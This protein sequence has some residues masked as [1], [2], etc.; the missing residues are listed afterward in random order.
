[1]RMGDE[2]PRASCLRMH[3]F[4][5]MLLLLLLLLWVSV[6]YCSRRCFAQQS[7]VAVL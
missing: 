1:M 6:C 5:G 4:Q 7:Y 2:Q 3:M